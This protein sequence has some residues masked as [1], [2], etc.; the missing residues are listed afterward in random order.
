MN[1]FIPLL[2]RFFL[3]AIFLMSGFGKISN[4]TGTQKFMADAGMPLTGFL[5]LCA[6]VIEIFGGLSLLLG[7]KIKYGAY[8]LILFLIPATI[9]FHS[10]FTDQG[11]MIMFLKNLSILGGLLMVAH[12]GAGSLSIDTRLKLVD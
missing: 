1:K 10:N 5:L 2:G 4:Y 9:M 6:I 11:Q 7:Y 3:S 12:F 8:A